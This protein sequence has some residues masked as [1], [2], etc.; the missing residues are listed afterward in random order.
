MPVDAAHLLWAVSLGNVDW[1]PHPVRRADLDHP[2]ELRVDIDPMP[3]A[4][5][6]HVRRVALLADE[7][8]REH[9]LVG[10]PR[11]SG[12]R[13]MHVMVR[14]HPRWDFT[15]VRAAAL[16]LARE[17][18]HR[19]EGMATSTWWREERPPDAVFVD[20]NQ[21]AKDHTV[22]AGYSIRPV[23][24]A[25]VACHLAWD[26]VPDCELGDFR[27]DTVPERLRTIGDP[28]ATIDDTAGSLDS[29]LELALIDVSAD[30]ALA[31]RVAGHHLDRRVGAAE[32]VAAFGLQEYPPEWGA[33]A[34]LRAR[35]L[36]PMPADV[37][38][39]N[40]FRGSPYVVLRADA[41]IFTAA[42]V[43]EDEA[44]LK[45]LVGSRTAKEVDRGG[46]RGRR[47]AGSRRRRRAGR[48]RGRP[49]RPRRLPPGDARAAAR[50]PAALVPRLREPPRPP[51]LLA[52]ARAARGHRD[53][54][55]G[56]VGARRPA[57]NAAR[58]G[59]RR[60]RPPLPARLRPGDAL[61][62][63]LAGA[64]RC[65]ACETALR[66]DRGRARAGSVEGRQ[67]FVLA[68]DVDRLESPPAASGVRLLGGHDP[69]VAQPD[70]EAL[71][72]DA[73]VRK[74]LFPSVGRPGA[75][76]ADGVLAG[77]WRGYKKG[78]V[79]EVGVEWLGDAVDVAEE[80][81][82]GRLPR[83]RQPPA[84]C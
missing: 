75:V 51:R 60:A 62:A 20:Y 66:R 50:R 28:S 3:D 68:A 77:L 57:A 1:N 78:D 25:R 34:A 37:V 73:A 23:P 56:D 36:E 54:G 74:R 80:A 33:L 2:D 19:S 45:S 17:V 53:A 18:E 39:V 29:L 31:F 14:I 64:V 71:V 47:G 65:V 6:D 22:A 70:R 4:P 76:L 72:P 69:Y 55:E 67:G 13:G 21:N 82:D 30:Q 58:R 5:W 8:L 12:S 35:S 61:T 16:A 81:R 42:L 26:E 15:T 32:A 11:T 40:A 41:R 46:L 48:A 38:Q 10:F 9:G 79:L 7:V 83:V 44:G 24:D 63:R 59:A 43:P 49:A 27:I 52:R 84:S